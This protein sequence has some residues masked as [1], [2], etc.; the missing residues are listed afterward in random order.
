M[1]LITKYIT[2]NCGPT[3]QAANVQ[4]PHVCVKGQ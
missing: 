3:A 2:V 1:P 4:T